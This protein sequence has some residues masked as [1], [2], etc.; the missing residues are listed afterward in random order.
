MYSCLNSGNAGFDIRSQ[1]TG[2]P[3]TKGAHNDGFTKSLSIS[4]L[5]STVDNPEGTG[6]KHAFI[7]IR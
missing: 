2:G 1:I 6:Y 3:S 7:N 5:N 4:L